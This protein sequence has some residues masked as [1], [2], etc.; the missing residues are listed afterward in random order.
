[1]EEK[2]PMAK[3]L[4]DVFT[5]VSS[6]VLKALRE[7]AM[8]NGRPFRAVMEAAVQEFLTL[9]QSRSRVEQLIREYTA[10]LAEPGMDVA[11]VSCQLPEEFVLKIDKLA[12]EL[13]AIKQILYGTAAFDFWRKAATEKLATIGPADETGGGEL[14]G[15]KRRAK[16]RRQK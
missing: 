4:T 2:G 3:K 11:R 10:H 13:P 15:K 14:Q 1:M 8:D 6:T 7:F 5:R 12:E 9:A 16:R